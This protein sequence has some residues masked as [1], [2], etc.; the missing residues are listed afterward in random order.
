MAEIQKRLDELCQSITDCPHSTPKW[1][2]SGNSVIRNNNIKNGRLDL[3]N[4]SF[5]D[6]V[7]FN[8]RIQRATPE[9]GDIII[10][11]EAPMGEVCRIP[12]GLKCCLGQRMVLLKPNYDLVDGDYLLFVLMSRGV[13]TQIMWSEGTGSTVSNL[14]IPHLCALSI[15]YLPIEKQRAIGRLLAS[16]DEKIEI[17]KQ[18]NDNLQQQAFAVF[19]NLLK[20]KQKATVPLSSV[21]EI[22]PKRDLG[23]SISARCIDMARLSTSGSFP[24]GWDIKPYNGGMKFRNG[25]TLLARITPCLENGKTAFIDFLDDGEVAFGSTE[26]IVMCPKGDLPPEFLYCLARYPSFVDYAVKNMNGSSGRQRVSAETIGKYE[27]PLLSEEDIEPFVSTVP[28]LFRAM[29]NNAFENMSLADL[30][31]ALLPR[32]MSGDIDVSAIDV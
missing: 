24:D 20:D 32:L 13:Q 31:D 9:S 2:S 21:A 30:R 17:N 28:G 7:D 10:T 11:R 25:D 5:T 16:L 15:P 19:D 27:I 4:P 12:T 26:Y 29:R 18:I 23:K 6:D 3:S 8:K 1:T 22:N 14:R